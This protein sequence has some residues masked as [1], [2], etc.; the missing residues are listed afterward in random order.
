MHYYQGLRIGVDATCRMRK[1]TSLV[2]RVLSLCL[3]CRR[4]ATS[5]R[6]RVRTPWGPGRPSAIGNRRRIMR[7][8]CT[9]AS[10]FAG[11]RFTRLPGAL[12]RVGN[13]RIVVTNRGHE[14]QTDCRPFSQRNEV[15]GAT[16]A[17]GL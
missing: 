3:I 1:S 8:V 5:S 6:Y 15:S 16:A 12:S 2:K 17:R 13:R 14:R 10:L 11:V 4:A 7:N 9:T